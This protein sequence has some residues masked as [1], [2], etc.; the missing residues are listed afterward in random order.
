MNLHPVTIDTRIKLGIFLMVN[1]LIFELK[2]ILLGGLMFAFVCFLVILMGQGKIAKKYIITYLVLAGISYGCVILPAGLMSIISI[3][4][5][6]MRVM[7]PVLLFASAFIETTTVGELIAA[8]YAM[9]MPKAIVITFAM[10]LRFFPT[11]KEEIG[12]VYDAMKLRGLGL[13]LTN[14]FKR[15]GMMFEAVVIPI[16]MRSITIAEELSASAV[17]RGIDNPGKRTTFIRLKTKASDWILFFVVILYG[18]A[19]LILKYR[20]YGRLG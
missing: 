3:L 4:T 5:L 6:F 10:T 18:T 9:H 12:M 1:F 17:T 16:V 13:S 11:F 19:L 20:M 14:I 7:L 15:P 8:M 2:T